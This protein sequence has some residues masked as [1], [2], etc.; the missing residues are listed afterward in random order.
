[1]RIAPPN[2]L[3]LDLFAGSGS[4]GVACLRQ[5]RRF[6]GVERSPVNFELACDRLRAEEQ[7]ST[8]DASRAGQVALFGVDP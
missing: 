2:G 7:M 3:V 1:M 4:T 5:G 8:L 6:I